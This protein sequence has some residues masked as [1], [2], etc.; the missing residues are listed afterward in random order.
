MRIVHFNC[1]T[2]LDAYIRE[3]TDE[4]F[5]EPICWDD[6]PKRSTLETGYTGKSFDLTGKDHKDRLVFVEVKLLKYT[7][8]GWTDRF[9]KAVGQLLHYTYCALY[10][11]GKVPEPSEDIKR[12]IKEIR[13]FIVCESFSP[14]VK[15]ICRML[16]AFGINIKHRYVNQG[17]TP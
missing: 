13:L 11:N 5:D 10:P 3:H 14:P 9:H 17:E 2:E 8:N 6:P 16:Q 15:N 12:K 7:S 1:E 4:I